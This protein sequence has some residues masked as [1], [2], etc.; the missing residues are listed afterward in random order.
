MLQ[1]LVT[2]R[3]MRQPK[4]HKSIMHVP[5]IYA[6]GPTKCRET[7]NMPQFRAIPNLSGQSGGW[8]GVGVGVGVGVRVHV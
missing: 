5:L 3:Y 1:V 7:G 8:V 6:P 4:K 2:N